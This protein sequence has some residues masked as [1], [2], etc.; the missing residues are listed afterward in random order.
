MCTSGGILRH[1]G[2]LADRIFWM[3]QLDIGF[4]GED[5]RCRGR[6]ETGL[7]KVFHLEELVLNAPASKRE[8]PHSSA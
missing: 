8:S 1:E 4:R 5:R 2:R 6:L 3:Q 7:V